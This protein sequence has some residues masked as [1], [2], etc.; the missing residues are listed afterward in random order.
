MFD[1]LPETLT[2]HIFEVFLVADITH[3]LFECAVVDWLL[4]C[5]REKVGHDAIEELQVVL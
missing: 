5:L 4:F 2:V 3:G 1:V